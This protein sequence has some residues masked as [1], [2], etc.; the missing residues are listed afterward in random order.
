MSK[1][2]IKD[3][4]ILSIFTVVLS[5]SVHQAKGNALKVAA[6]MPYPSLWHFVCVCVTKM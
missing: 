2:R 4:T 3:V 1:I 6:P 5:Q